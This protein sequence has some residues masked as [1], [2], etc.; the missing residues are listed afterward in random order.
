[1]NKG[2]KIQLKKQFEYYGSTSFLIVNIIGAG[3]FVASAGV[4]KYSCMNVGLSLCI[5]AACALLSVMST[6]CLA[7][8]GRTFPCSGPHYYFLRRYFGNLISFLNIWRALFLG[9]GIA[10]SHALLLTEYSI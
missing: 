7:E 8:I 3:I 2:K 4:L 9:P 5:W 10:A 6:L 1:M